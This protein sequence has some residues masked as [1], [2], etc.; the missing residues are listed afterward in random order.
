MKR[1]GEDVWSKESWCVKN[2]NKSIEFRCRDRAE[3]IHRQQTNTW[4][5]SNHRALLSFTINYI[6]RLTHVARN[7]GKCYFLCSA[8]C[9]KDLSR[10]LKT[11]L[12]E[13]I[14][15]CSRHVF[16]LWAS[17]HR[18]KIIIYSNLWA[19]VLLIENEQTFALK[20]ASLDISKLIIERI[21][22]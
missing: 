11:K 5:L 6:F 8:V 17:S 21:L 7:Y 10:K 22:G 1:A 14:Y 16:H 2:F 19:D 18:P 15:R 9:C 4:K 13:R 3:R 20:I 12:S